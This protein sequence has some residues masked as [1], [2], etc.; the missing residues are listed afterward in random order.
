[1]ATVVEPPPGDAIS[2][3]VTVDG[4]GENRRSSSS[5]SVRPASSRRTRPV[6]RTGTTNGALACQANEAP[7]RSGPSGD[8][9][10]SQP[11]IRAGSVH[12]DHSSAGSALPSARTGTGGITPPPHPSPPPLLRGTRAPPPRGTRG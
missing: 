2:S 3:T 10:G 6:I 11:D 7:S 12:N 1:M 8:V 4:V 5:S 9:T